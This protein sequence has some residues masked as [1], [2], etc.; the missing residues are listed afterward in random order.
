MS[1]ISGIR[2]NSHDVAWMS[3]VG[4]YGLLSTED[5]FDFYADHKPNSVQKRLRLLSKNG[6]TR[7]TKLNVWWAEEKSSS[8]GEESRRCM[9]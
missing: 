7:M 5:A 6:L 2:I 1:T 9:R 4:R 8:K 3:G